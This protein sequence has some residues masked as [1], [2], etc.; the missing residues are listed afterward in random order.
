MSR[1]YLD[2][3]TQAEAQERLGNDEPLELIHL[4]ALAQV[5]AQKFYALAGYQA[6]VTHDFRN[7]SHPHETRAWDQGC[8]A[9]EVLRCCEMDDVL[10]EYLDDLEAVKA[11]Y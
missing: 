9:V 4:L 7:S 6:P 5:L 11:L 10:A 3:T 8:V 1:T 2:I